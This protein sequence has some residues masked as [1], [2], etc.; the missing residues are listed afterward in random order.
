MNLA[1]WLR[2]A[3]PLLGL[4]ITWALFAALAPG[5]FPTWSNQKLMLLQTVVVGIAAVGA[6]WIIVSGGID[7]S[8]GAN[9]ALSSTVGALVMKAGHGFVPA[10]L[11]TVLT[12]VA[13][14]WLIGALVV[15][16]LLR[17]LVSGAAAAA[18]IFVAAGL[19]L[20]WSGLI[21]FAVGALAW[22]ASARV[23]GAL[24][25]SPFIVTLGLWGALRGAAKGISD[26][27]G[28][29]FEEQPGFDTL[30]ALMQEGWL[31]APGVWVLLLV[32]A[33]AAL[34]LRRSVFGRHVTALGSSRETARLCG[35]DLPR[36]ELRVY[37]LACMLAGVAAVL[38][39][40]YLTVGDPTTAQG[41]E[42][43]AIAAAVIGGASL[44]GGEGA[45]LGTLL[46]ALIMTVVNNGCAKVGLDNWVQEIVTGAIIVAAVAL[47]RW[48]QG[49][50]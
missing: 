32:A 49:R 19:G 39:L 23:R 10:A 27:Q 50:S 28:V 3:G 30:C 35:I 37:V 14:G 2:T 44:A 1:R 47:D 8:V 29:Y 11:A 31:L 26:S 13:C 42:L 24:P 12:G 43:K 38:Q 4:L 21:G 18:A 5:S 15:G 41:L 25:L 9:I 48:R 22:L 34:L 16:A 17:V 40:S 6:T 36:V 20:W 46:G 45:I 7:L 33:L